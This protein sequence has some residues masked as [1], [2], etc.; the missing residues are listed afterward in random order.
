MAKI[1]RPQY[2]WVLSCNLQWAQGFCFRFGCGYSTCQ[3]LLLLCLSWEKVEFRAHKSLPQTQCVSFFLSCMSQFH[4]NLV[5]WS[6]VTMTLY[7]GPVYVSL[8]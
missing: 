2:V 5:W 3:S 8:I 1:L 6:I 4:V 7:V